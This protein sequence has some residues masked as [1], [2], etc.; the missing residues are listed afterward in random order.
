MKITNT[1]NL[2][3]NLVAAIS[4]DERDRGGA[5]YTVTELLKPA[6][7][8]ALE[9]LHKGDLV[10]DASE[11]IWA[12]LG[13]AG[14]EVLRKSAHGKGI[15]EERAVIDIEV[16]G[17]KFKVSG[18]LDFALTETA[19]LSDFKFTSVWAIKEGCKPEWEQQA[20]LYRCLAHQYG[21]DFKQIEII[22][23]ARDWSVRDAKRDSSYP[24]AQVVVFKPRVWTIDE[25]MS[26]M[27]QRIAIH[28]AARVSLPDCTPEE[29]WEKPE[30][31]ATMKKG[32]VKAVKLH[33]DFEG[34]QAHANS[35]GGY[36]EHRPAQRPRCES[37]CAVAEWCVQ[38]STWK[39]ANTNP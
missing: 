31:W 39:A 9:H 29:V 12:L 17:K 15:V 19:T 36:V 35:C 20:N 28:E 34:A 8:T 3:L 26:F 18:Q 22:A 32:R 24:Q 16:G 33:P 13:R 7:I 11:R 23:I 14:H 5:D 30:K 25:A 1:Q 10:E 6:R 38:Y 21:V 4:F 27:A 37:Y 2:P